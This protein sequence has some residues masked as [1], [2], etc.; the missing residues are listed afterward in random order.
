MLCLELA[1]KICIEG[2]SKP[3]FVL[4]SVVSVLSWRRQWLSHD[5]FRLNLLKIMTINVIASELLSHR[6][7]VT[8]R[9]RTDC[10]FSKCPMEL[11]GSNYQFSFEINYMASFTGFWAF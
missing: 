11:Y 1:V 3:S 6:L 7:S 2:Q 9:S 4:S 5:S 8:D 10:A